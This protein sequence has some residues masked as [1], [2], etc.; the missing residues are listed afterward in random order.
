M[1]EK[2]E[3]VNQDR[4]V[5]EKNLRR[6]RLSRSEYQKFLKSLEDESARGEELVVYKEDRPRQQ[7]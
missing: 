5:M 7:S 4:R 1:K 2:F 3:F 6:H